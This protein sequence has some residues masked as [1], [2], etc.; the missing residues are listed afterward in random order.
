MTSRQHFWKPLCWTGSGV[1]LP[2]EEGGPWGREKFAQDPETTRKPPPFV[3]LGDG[4]PDKVS[5]GK[6]V[7]VLKA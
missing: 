2:G 5:P 1:R 7:L 3:R 6:L 4:T